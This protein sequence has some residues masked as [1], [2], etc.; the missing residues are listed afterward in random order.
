V[1]TGG[2]YLDPRS[3]DCA[4]EALLSRSGAVALA[5][6][7][8]AIRVPLPAHEQF[9]R[10]AVLPGE[11]ETVVDF[12]VPADRMTVVAIWERAQVVGLA[13][14]AVRLSGDPG[15]ALTL[16][17]V[18][19]KH[20][21][22]VWLG[23]LI[24]ADQ[25]SATAD[26]PPLDPSLLVPVRPRTATVHKN[27]Y[28]V[29]T[30]VDD[31][32]E[33]MLGWSGAEMIGRRSLD[34][35]HPDDHERAI[36]QWLEMRARR[37]STRVRV[38]HRHRDGSW[39][40]VEMENSFV[41]LDD[42]GR[43]VAVCEVSDISDEMAAHEAVRQRERLFHRLAESLPDGLFLVGD[44]KEI[45]YANARLGSILGVRDATDL[46]QQ[47]ASVAP[48][49]RTRLVAALE[50]AVHDRRDR[51]V[52][53]EV[54]VPGSG[55]LRW[56]LATVTALSDEEGL[57]GA[58]V[59][60]S[61]VT[62]SAILREELRH[63]ATHDSLTG[64]FN[65]ASTLAALGRILDDEQSGLATVL[66]VDLDHFK[67]LNDTFGHAVGDRFLADAA[68]RIAAQARGDDVVGRIGGDEFLMIC[69]GIGTAP[70]A[71]DVAE[72]LQQT[73]TR[74]TSVD[75]R[76]IHLSASIGVTIASPGSSVNAVI[77]RADE[78]MYLSK[79]QPQRTPVF[80]ECQDVTAT[81]R[82]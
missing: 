43:L 40:W 11:R 9:A 45:V 29:I 18:D 67:T 79:R 69:Q 41:G 5:L 28:A 13:Q 23:F 19:L 74:S 66:F 77:T 2:A 32:V 42:P 64:C 6:T 58:M 52:E 44:D 7:D 31:R 24:T 36:G 33:R 82:P 60:L 27:L 8:A 1:V 16:T 38:R 56:C 80:L 21:F 55:L 4:V 49:D 34:F 71:L 26:V 37:Q 59:T 75:G 14:G 51:Q 63:Q 3:L 25:W 68:R 50:A 62:E 53:I 20:R 48:D 73:L 12:V 72:R 54:L 30:Y 10:V 22:G 35:V 81:F 57:S 61:D 39:L 15:R 70:E 65:Q 78:A 76:A 46:T 47:L 17:I